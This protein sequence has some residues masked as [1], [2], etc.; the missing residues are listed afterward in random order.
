[1]VLVPSRASFAA[2]AASLAGVDS[3]ASLAS[4]ALGLEVGLVAVDAPSLVVQS[5]EEVVQLVGLEKWSS[6]R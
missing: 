3:V 5:P 2:S 6:S 1:M 4:P